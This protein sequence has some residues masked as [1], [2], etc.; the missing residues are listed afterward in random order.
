M[1]L[2]CTRAFELLFFSSV[3]LL[4]F[5]CSKDSDLLSDYVIADKNDL[6]SIAV[7][8]DDIYYI[9]NGQ[10]SM[11]LDVLR[12]DSFSPDTEV[13]IVSTS[14]PNNGVVV[15]NIDNTLTY[16]PNAGVAEEDASTAEQQISTGDGSPDVQEA[17][18]EDSFDYTTEVITGEGETFREQATVTITPSD[19]GE[20]L[21]FPGAKGFGK[22]TTGGR[23]G[24]I[25]HVTNLNDSGA[26]SLREALDSKGTRTI[27]FDVGGDIYLTGMHLNIGDSQGNLTI[28]GETAPF[29]GITIRG[30]NISSKSYGGTIDIAASNV[31]IRYISIRE[32]NNNRTDND[33]IRIRN[34]M[35]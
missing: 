21:A 9:N 22:F 32:N 5:S 17:V 24:R 30:D 6:Q 7:L 18:E 11:L 16:T 10:S 2:P 27:V 19:M 15:I 31:I 23:G 26:G 25:I 33:A 1:K 20:L 4:H 13:N 12:N 29:P 14:E 28:A 35:D 8:A 3:I 34:N